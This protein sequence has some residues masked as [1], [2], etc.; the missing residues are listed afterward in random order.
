[1]SKC[2]INIRK[3]TQPQLNIYQHQ[4]KGHLCEGRREDTG[5]C[6]CSYNGVLLVVVV[7]VE[8]YFLMYWVLNS[9]PLEPHP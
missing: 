5:I 1:M 8:V 9:G 4:Q 7:V 3:Y 6:S 2:P